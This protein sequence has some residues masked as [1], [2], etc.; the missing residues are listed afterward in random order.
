M[1][2]FREMYISSSGL[3]ICCFILRTLGVKYKL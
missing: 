3:L 2:D 1:H